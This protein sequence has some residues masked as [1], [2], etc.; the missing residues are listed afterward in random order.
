[1]PSRG[2]PPPLLWLLL[3]TAFRQKKAREKKEVRRSLSLPGNSEEEI[4]F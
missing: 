1:L 3:K 4:L 2:P